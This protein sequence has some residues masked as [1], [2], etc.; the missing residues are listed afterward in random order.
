MMS[1]NYETLSQPTIEGC[2]SATLLAAFPK[3]TRPVSPG[4]ISFAH[5]IYIIKIIT[6]G[7]AS[8]RRLLDL[9]TGTH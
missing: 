6:D 7:P 3:H 9:Q 4:E 5:M 2:Y 8:P 1:C